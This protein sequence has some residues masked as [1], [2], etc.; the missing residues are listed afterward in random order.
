[1]PAPAMVINMCIVESM[2]YIYKPRYPASFMA[3]YHL[4]CIIHI[5]LKNSSF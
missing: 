4:P 2:N 1:M 5:I 3:D